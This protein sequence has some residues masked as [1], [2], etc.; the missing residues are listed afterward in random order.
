MK[1]DLNLKEKIKNKKID[2]GNLFFFIGPPCTGKTTYLKE[3]KKILEKMKIYYVN[4]IKK[5]DGLWAKEN[6]II[7][8][9][10]L[11]HVDYLKYI[12]TKDIIYF[13]EDE[14]VLK[15]IKEKLIK[16]KLLSINIIAKIN[17]F[18]DLY[19]L[20]NIKEQINIQDIYEKL[21]YKIKENAY[22]NRDKNIY[23]CATGGFSPL[24]KP[25]DYN[26]NLDIYIETDE[27]TLLKQNFE[28]F[29]KSGQV[30]LINLL[31]GEKESI[32]FKNPINYHD[33]FEQSKKIYY[34]ISTIHLKNKTNVINE[35]VMYDN[36][37]ILENI[38]KII[39]FILSSTLVLEKNNVEA[40]TK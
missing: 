35:S 26:N 28:R 1:I 30:E 25:S 31:S 9:F 5:A 15:E 34:D 19:L 14:L 4:N 23:L 7:M 10:Y 11:K 20:E 17:E 32:D 6:K 40:I 38:L 33:F 37:Q 39:E 13:D 3:I 24:F 36:I 18:N 8:D 12:L 22:K 2:L 16:E 21:L 29:K 27:K